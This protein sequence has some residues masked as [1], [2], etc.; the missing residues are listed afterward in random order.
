MP[1]SKCRMRAPRHLSENAR[2]R[3]CTQSSLAR[4]PSAER[5]GLAGARGQG[6]WSGKLSV[7]PNEMVPLQIDLARGVGRYLAAVSANHAL[8]HSGTSASPR[9]VRKL[10]MTVVR[11]SQLVARRR[12]LGSHVDRSRQSPVGSMPKCHLVG[13]HA[14]TSGDADS[15]PAP[16]VRPEP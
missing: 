12:S 16:Q 3:T 8:L 15:A 11:C 7:C 6:L 4:H 5:G 13:H 10:W 14:D 2:R 9:A 1:S